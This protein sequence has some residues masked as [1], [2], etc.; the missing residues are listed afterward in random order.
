MS[1]LTKFRIGR[2]TAA[3]AGS[4]LLL[5]VATAA[6]PAV[7]ASAATS[8]SIVNLYGAPRAPGMTA[9]AAAAETGA[10][11][12]PFTTV[13]QAAQSAH[14]LSAS[15]D[16]VVHLAAGKYPLTQPLTFT[17]ADAAQNGHTIS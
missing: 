14:Q 16:V 1:R 2:A 7:A 11:Q 17:G 15:A 5:L 4:A 8:P 12:H 9:A 6:L 10:A 3:T 13:A